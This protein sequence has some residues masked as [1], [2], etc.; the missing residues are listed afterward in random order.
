M[1]TSRLHCQIS[2]PVALV[3]A[4]ESSRD[5]CPGHRTLRGGGTYAECQAP[6]NSLE[7]TR[8]RRAKM[9]AGLANGA[10]TRTRGGLADEGTND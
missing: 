1:I 10:T 5:S 6:N 3:S 8:E 7:P 9:E 2:F 4:T